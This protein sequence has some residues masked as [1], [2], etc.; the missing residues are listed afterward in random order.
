M[1]T[2]P[3]EFCGIPTAHFN[4]IDR[5]FVCPY[6]TAAVVLLPSAAQGADIRWLGISLRNADLEVFT[7]VP[8]GQEAA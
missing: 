4:I 3:C 7:A 1:K 6:C 2:Q 8:L 5:D